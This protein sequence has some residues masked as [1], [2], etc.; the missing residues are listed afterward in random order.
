MNNIDKRL[1]VDACSNSSQIITDVFDYVPSSCTGST[2][3]ISYGKDILDITYNEA[4]RLFEI[5]QNQE[6]LDI[7]IR[8]IQETNRIACDILFGLA[9]ICIKWISEVM[10]KVV[11]VAYT[12]KGDDFNFDMPKSVQEAVRI[13][14]LS[15][16]RILKTGA[17][18]GSKSSIQADR[19]GAGSIQND[20]GMPFEKFH[21]RSRGSVYEII[22]S[23]ITALQAGL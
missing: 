9:H 22:E 12:E 18:L 7:W 6:T 21:A 14:S 1:G 10:I 15:K 3:Q 4:F 23:Y 19:A 5:V 17:A 2:L 8:Y 20:R 11:T 16:D 13:I